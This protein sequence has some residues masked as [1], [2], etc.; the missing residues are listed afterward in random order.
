MKIENYRPQESHPHEIARFDV[1][2]ERMGLTLHEFKAIRKKDGGWFIAAPNFSTEKAGVKVFL[3]YFS[4]SEK[5]RKV[6]FDTAYK[7]VKEKIGED[8]SGND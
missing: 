2:L 5:R 7:L 1:E 3:P 8:P 4:L 6:F